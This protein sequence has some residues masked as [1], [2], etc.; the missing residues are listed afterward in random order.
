MGEGHAS[1]SGA[2]GWCRGAGEAA[3]PAAV[4]LVDYRT[5]AAIA[6]SGLLGNLA[7][8]EAVRVLSNVPRCCESCGYSGETA[9]CERRLVCHRKSLAHVA[10]PERSSQGDGS[11]RS[12]EE[13][14]HQIRFHRRTDHCFANLRETR[15]VRSEIRTLGTQKPR[16]AAANQRHSKPPTRAVGSGLSVHSKAL[17]HNDLRK[18]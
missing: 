17:T 14:G 10:V 16:P 11:W 8:D 7:H 12:D 3:H 5:K 4:L 18:L 15:L 2:G 13:E 6:G 1:G 9:T